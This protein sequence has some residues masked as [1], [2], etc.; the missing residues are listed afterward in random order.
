[1]ETR[2]VVH[3]VAEGLITGMA[4]AAERH[5]AAGL[6]HFP[7]AIENVYRAFNEQGTI[8]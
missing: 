8:L 4:A 7:L 6:H 5:L 3:A 2:F 1:L